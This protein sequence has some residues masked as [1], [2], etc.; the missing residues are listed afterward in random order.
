MHNRVFFSCQGFDPRRAQQAQP[1]NSFVCVGLICVDLPPNN[2]DNIG[3]DH[4]GNTK[5]HGDGNDGG[6]PQQRRVTNPD[7]EIAKE[8][9]VSQKMRNNFDIVVEQASP[10]QMAEVLSKTPLAT[11]KASPQSGNFLCHLD[12]N[13]YGEAT[14]LPH[15]RKVPMGKD[16]YQKLFKP[17]MIARYGKEMADDIPEHLPVGDIFTMLD[18]NK[19]R[20]RLFKQAL[21]VHQTTGKNK[22]RAK[23]YVCYSSEESQSGRK[24][25]TRALC[26]SQ[27]LWRV[28]NASTEIPT[29]QYKEMSGSNKSDMF[30]PVELEKGCDLPTLPSK[31]AKAAWWGK[32]RLL[33]VGGKADADEAEDSEDDEDDVEANTAFNDDPK[34]PICYHQMP[35]IILKEL[36]WSMN[37]KH[38]LDLAPS[39]STA[40]AWLIAEA[41]ASYCC[42]ASTET[43]A[44]WFRQ[45]VH[46]DLI[47]MCSQEGTKLYAQCQ[48][49][50]GLDDGEE[51]KKKKDQPAQKR[52]KTEPSQNTG[53]GGE[54]PNKRGKKAE[55]TSGNTGGKPDGGRGTGGGALD[56][57]ALLAVAK[58]KAKGATAANDDGD[59][60]SGEPA[61]D[62]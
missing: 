49:W 61:E 57:A 31:A 9:L 59:G 3:S 47:K 17:V 27:G 39:P 24:A 60:D 40:A 37:V 30:G 8:R 6:Q 4:D 12:C 22:N 28:M 19:D 62:E 10:F 48:L 2:E 18:A 13:H 41:G 1:Q 43:S 46:D 34:V 26:C 29:K 42:I 25:K 15:I 35:P 52:Q 33:D 56:V 21:K 53:G 38:V 20:K 16:V 54:R 50:A 7:L 55:K 51:A 44:T 58:A 32:D 11:V 23:K 36:V 45:K 14:S 5:L